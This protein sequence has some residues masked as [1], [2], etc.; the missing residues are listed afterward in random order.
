MVSNLNAASKYS[1]VKIRKA[2]LA[3][4]F[5]LTLASTVYSPA[6]WANVYPSSEMASVRSSDES[7]IRELRS[8]EIQ[9]LRKTLGRR[10]PANRKADLYVRLAETYLEAYRAEF[11]NEGR[12]HEKRLNDGQTEKFIDRGNSRPYLR[13]GIRACEEV[14]RIGIRHPKLDQ[15]YYFLGVY[16]DELED[17]KNSIKYFREL[18]QRFPSSPYVGESYRAV[19]ESL[20]AKQNYGE[21]LKFYELA[22]PR[23]QGNALPRLLQKKAWCHYRMKQYDRAVNVMKTAISEAGKDERF[24]S[25]KDE[26]LRDM[27]TFMTESGRV[28]EAL[29]YFK[30]VGGDKD[31]YPRT[32]ERLGAQYERNAEMKKAVMVYEA[33]LR[34][35]PDPKDEAAFRVRVKLVEL[36][37]KRGLYASAVKRLQG[38]NIPSSGE[39]ET[40]V[41]V[42]NLRVL[43]RKTAID[44]HENFRKTQNK[45]SL[46]AAENFYT[47]YLNQFL[48]KKDDKKETPEIQMYLAEVKRDIGKPQDAAF[49]YKQVIR[50]KDDR[51]AKQA[52]AFWMSSLGETIANA[53]KNGKTEDISGYEKDFIEASDYVADNFG[54]KVE[55]LQAQLN[56]IIAIAANPQRLSETESRIEKL[57]KT[58]PGSQQALTAARLHAQLYSDRLPKKADEVQESKAAEKLLEVIKDNRENSELMSADTKLQKGA[59]AAFMEGEEVRIKIGVIAGQEKSKD[60]ASAAKGYEDFAVRESKRDLSEKAFDNSVSNYVKMQ[61]YDSAIRVA[62]LWNE[63]YKDS[64]S[65]TGTFRDIATSAI[66]NGQ[67]EKAAELFRMIGRRGDPNSIEVAG[68]LFEGAGN[69]TEAATDFRYYLDTFKKSGNRG[70]VALSLSDW[71]AYSKSD[72]QAIR[73]LKL[74]FDENTETSAECGARLADLYERLEDLEQ[75]N[76]Y[77]QAVAARG[78]VRKG[79]KSKSDTSPWVGYARYHNAMTL[80]R[81][82]QFKR[83]ALPDDKLKRGLEERIKFLD[84]LNKSYQGVVEVSGPWAVAALDRLATWVMNFAD[85]VDQIEA[86]ATANAA[87]VAGLRKGLKTVS[88][89]LRQKAVDMWRTAYQKAVERE[90]LSPVLPAISDRL[91]DFGVVPPGRAQGFRDKFRLNGQPADGGKEG[92][93]TAFVRVRRVLTE[94]AK[95]PLAWIDYGNLLWGEGKP[96]LAKIAYE[97]ALLLNPKAAAALNNR[98]VLIASGSGQEDWIR[99]A[100]ANAYFKQAIDKDGLFL[101][102]KFNRGAILNYYRLFAKAKPYWN[103]VAAVAPQTDVT[104]GIAISE[105]GL[106]SIEA[107]ERAFGR[108]T[109]SG[110]SSDRTSV[111]YHLAARLSRSDPGKCA[112]LTSRLLDE[113]SGFEHQAVKHLN[114]FCTQSSGKK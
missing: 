59:L 34:T 103:Q 93:P 8:Q 73:Y 105:Q 29:A 98:G 97:R 49:L 11:L 19:A 110:G 27:A 70:Q 47:I 3:L 63:K 2:I 55:G 38:V 26:A 112:K 66:I 104:D 36:D 32:L 76:R 21:A 86:P 1:K 25:L 31:F 53:K 40:E 20:F 7:K 60:F 90:L 45:N 50:S 106:G 9:E 74:C 87:S 58:A 14:I 57:V 88:D 23:Y 85:E 68:R 12:V 109:K 75:S 96:L 101:A 18:A 41:A 39:N 15:I 95:D 16:Y 37:L 107:A 35:N 48:A 113:T 81:D 5:A 94:N 82:T 62:G 56:V 10:M 100:E 17:E 13:L 79:S 89:P 77:F 33:L 22:L 24:L 91:A 78:A 46:A 69:L 61:D 102:A 84:R 83:L 30:Q 43:L 52:A 114:E 64:K 80:E 108:G 4:S 54:T 71:Y 44:S 28:E 92:R 65:A 111:V 42:T 67:F 51:Y 6:V 99:V 72:T